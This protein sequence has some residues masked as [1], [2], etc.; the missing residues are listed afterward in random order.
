MPETM[1]QLSTDLEQ[2]V[3]VTEPAVVRVEARPRLP[4]S[5]VAWSDDGVIV[6][7]HHVIERDENIEVGLPDGRTVPAS[8]VG[9]DPTT[10]V[11]VLRASDVRLSPAN[12]ANPDGARVG[13][14]VLAM[15]RPGQSILAT[16][17]IISAQ[18]QGWRTP[19][20]GTVDRVL[21]T[22]AV[23]FPGF[24]GGPLI[25]S[26]GQAIGMNTSALVHGVAVAVP[27]ATLGRVVEALLTDGR[28]KRG[29]L[30]V[31]AQPAR[32]SAALEQQVGQETGL[33]LVSVEPD[34]PAENAGLL[35]G[36][37]IIAINGG[38]TRHLDDLL[39]FL[40]G[41]RAGRTATLSVVRGG[42]VQELATVIGER[43]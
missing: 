32:L 22:D 38:P 25:D 41:E 19:A 13:H 21:Q 5:G 26:S 7:A 12:W 23:M 17:G 35:L 3:E 4:A 42:S 16:L 8:L 33:L 31:G 34:S 10:D 30:G 28:I 20:G 40:A 29:Y 9:R 2:A 37:T 1:S 6:T 14:L 39:G 24:S 27:S 11:A 43:D 36:D 15:G 18:R